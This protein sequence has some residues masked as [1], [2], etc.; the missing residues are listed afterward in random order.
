MPTPLRF[1]ITRP[2]AG[3][4]LRLVLINDALDATYYAY[5][6]RSLERFAAERRVEFH[7]L[8]RRTVEKHWREPAQLASAI[9]DQIRPQVVVFNRYAV[10]RG[11]ELL[12][13]LRDRGIATLY[14]IDDDLL[15][16]PE[17][18]GASVVSH[19]G[20]RETIEERRAMLAL[21]DVAQPSTEQLSE[22]LRQR[23]PGCRL[24]AA[25]HPPFM[26][27]V[28]PSRAHAGAPTIGY[29]A[30]KSHA[31]D[32]RLILP[33]IVSLLEQRSTL[34]F[35]LFGTLPLPPELARFGARVL[36]HPPAANYEAFLVT[37][38][39]LGWR[40]GLAP[41]LDIP[42]NHCKSAIKFLEYTASG[43]PVV[44]SP[45]PVYERIL[46]HEH[47]GLLAASPADWAISIAKL[48]DQP[49]TA[50]ELA[51]RAA[52][53]CQQRY[54]LDAFGVQLLERLEALATLRRSTSS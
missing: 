40:T 17:D 15:S 7:V 18:L 44:A 27:I 49:D 53:D 4:P 54:D 43:I 25:M 16:I 47:N 13:L 33:A 1:D 52:Q 41:L 24:S 46:R 35:E 45:L 42:F 19:H 39:G 26:R 10:P 5:F 51:A 8:S 36:A 21:V 3:A 14:H 38:A 31:A 22:V 6:H 28:Q 2:V 48:I 32:L 29:M 37:L 30:S 50:E 34:R 12:R 20:A 23:V 11:S 9:D